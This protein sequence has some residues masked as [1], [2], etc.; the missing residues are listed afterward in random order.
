MDP[1]EKIPSIAVMLILFAFPVM[2]ISRRNMMMYASASAMAGFEIILLLTMQLVAGSMYQHTG[3]LLAGF[4][5]GLAA[6]AGIDFRQISSL[7]L[8]MKGL[9]LV[10][11]FA[12]TGLVYHFIES[13]GNIFT[14]IVILIILAFIPAFLTGSIFRDLTGGS[15]EAKSI[16]GIYSADLSGSAI[17]FIVIASLSVPLIGIRM[18]VFILSS[19][20]LAGFLLGSTGASD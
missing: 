17:G 13:R 8:K 18:S 2:T 4:M 1:G 9:I 11:F 16:S 5:S 10:L 7:S 20:V 14:S 19:I 15:K 12:F 3:L 6:G